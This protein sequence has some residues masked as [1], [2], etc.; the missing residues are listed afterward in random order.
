MYILRSSIM[1]T[2]QYGA[3]H[4]VERKG[5]FNPGV[6]KRLLLNLALSHV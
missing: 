6:D 1:K 2:A 3:Y 4:R 5:F